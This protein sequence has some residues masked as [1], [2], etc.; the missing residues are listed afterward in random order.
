MDRRKVNA[1]RQDHHQRGRRAPDLPADHRTEASCLGPL[2]VR[3]TER[4]AIA[5]ERRAGNSIRA[6]AALLT[7]APSTI[8]REINRNSDPGTGDYHPFA[9][10]QRAA[11]RRP[12]P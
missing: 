4:I 7:R 5:D 6:I 8:S 1:G 2:P 12:R 11:T 3:D 9:A 10:H